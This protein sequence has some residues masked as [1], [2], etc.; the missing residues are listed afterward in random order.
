MTEMQITIAEIVPGGMAAN[1]KERP[2]SIHTADGQKLKCWP[3][4]VGSMVAGRTYL[5]PVVAKQYQGIESFEIGSGIIKE[6]QQNH[7]VRSHT[8]APQGASPPAQAQPPANTPV[9]VANVAA[10][11]R[12]RSIQLLAI[13]KAVIAVGG[14]EGDVQRWV[15]CHDMGVAGKQVG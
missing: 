12:D 6:V 7:A 5:V 11:S 9:G 8:E 4:K 3:N 1:G 2:T 13:I 15:D 14:T 10:S